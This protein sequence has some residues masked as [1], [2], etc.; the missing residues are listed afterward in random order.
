MIN[1]VANIDARM[2]QQPSGILRAV[3]SRMSLPMPPILG[4]KTPLSKEKA[5]LRTL[6]FKRKQNII[7]PGEI[8][9]DYVDIIEEEFEN[10]D[11]SGGGIILPEQE[12]EYNFFRPIKPKIKRKTKYLKDC[13]VVDYIVAPKARCGMGAAALKD[14]AEK[15][16]FDPKIEGRIVTYSA[17]ACQESSPAIFFYKMGFRFMEPE[18]NERIVQCIIDKVPD[19]PPQTGMMYLPK[20]NLHKLLRYGEKF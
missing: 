14:L 2:R 13:Y 17:P 7:I 3:P 11:D 15:A 18:A 6:K 12:A 5:Q 10:D 1:N 19:T 9:D 20:Q 4:F 8:D 16:M